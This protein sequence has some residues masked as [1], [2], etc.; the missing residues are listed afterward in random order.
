MEADLAR[1]LVIE[2]EAKMKAQ[3]QTLIQQ[4]LRQQDQLKSQAELE[5]ERRAREE[6]EKK[7]ALESEGREIAS[8]SLGTTW[9]T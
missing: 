5:A 7:A 1:K 2:Q 4:E 3:A 6:A 8:R 9:I